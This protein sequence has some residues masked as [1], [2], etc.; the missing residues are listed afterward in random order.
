[1]RS[2]HTYLLVIVLFMIAFSLK[3]QGTENCFLADFEAKELIIPPSQDMEEPA[4]FPTVIIRVD[5][6]DALGRVSK[7][8]Y[9]NAV[10]AWLGN[11]GTDA[12]LLDHVQVLSP[13]LIRYPGGS[14][15]DIFF[16]NACDEND[17]P[18]VPDST[19]NGITGDAERFWPQFGTDC[20]GNWRMNWDNYNSMRDAVGC[21][22]LITINYGYARYGRSPDPVAQ[23]AH[24]AAEWVRDDGGRTKFW[25]IG[26]ENG[27]AWEA[28]WQ[29]DTTFNQ[30][31]Q[32]QIVSGELYGRHFKVFADSMRKAAVE[33]GA[34]IYIGAQ[35]MHFSGWNAVDQH[36]NEGVFSQI[37]DSADFYVIHNYYGSSSSNPLAYL[38]AATTVPK[39]NIDFIHQDITNKGAY[40]KPVALTE[41]NI[42]IPSEDWTEPRSSMINGMQAVLIFCELMKLNYGMSC[43]WLLV[44]WESDGMFYAGNN[45]SIPD[46]NP[47][48]AFFYLYYL[49]KYFGDHVIAVTSTNSNVAVYASTFGSGQMGVVVVNKD[50]SAQTAIVYLKDFLVDQK[51]YIYSLT[52]EIIGDENEDFPQGVNV[53]GHGPD[54]DAGTWGPLE[55]V[56]SNEIDA[57]AFLIGDDIKFTL[58]GRSVQFILIENGENILAVNSDKPLGVADQFALYT[59]YPNPFNP[60][61]KIHYSVN[62]ME[63]VS[64]K[65]YNMLGQLISILVEGKKAAG[66][67]LVEWDGKNLQGQRAGSGIYFYHMQAGSFTQTRKMILVK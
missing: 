53:N 19:I 11:V 45:A 1:M 46:W 40:V 33:I 47:R 54:S 15:S 56:K 44:N 39:Q 29:I 18:G 30:D 50:T 5:A 32:P 8:I 21:Q 49:Q 65:V 17:I 24:L 16:W 35:I 61:T 26:N 48:P 13:T 31:G 20:P 14:W 55:E 22:G 63:H 62:K 3:G 9:G 66:K 25:E 4:A 37:G 28:G 51:Y 36:W 60:V 67:Y 52:G 64:I 2:N 6:G 43:R 23:A 34:T 42:N 38:N 59:N 58:P 7:Y 27:G 41:W 12:D 57:Y 10:A